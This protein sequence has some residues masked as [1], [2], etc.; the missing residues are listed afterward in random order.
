[1]RQFFGLAVL[2]ALALWLAACSQEWAGDDDASPSDDDTTPSDDDD[3]TPSDD[4]DTSP[5]FTCDPDS[6]TS[7]VLA[8]E[9]LFDPADP[10][11][12]DT[13]TVIIRST[14]GTEPAAAP[15]MALQVEGATGTSVEPTTMVAGGGDTLYYYA[16]ADVQLGDVCLTGLIDGAAQEISGK[17][18]VTPRPAGPDA[19][20]GV[21]KVTTNHQWTCAEQPTYGNEIHLYVLDEHGAGVPGSPIRVDYADSTDFDSIHN[22]GGDIPYSVTTDSNGYFLGYDYWPISDHGFVVFQLYL[23]NIASDIATEITTGWWETDDS[24]CNYCSTYAINTWGHWSHTVIWQLDPDASEICV[25]ETDHAG[26]SVCGAPGHLHHH[27]DHRAC[28][29]RV[30]AVSSVGDVPQAPDVAELASVGRPVREAH[31]VPA[32][33]GVEDHQ[34]VGVAVVVPRE[35]VRTRLREQIGDTDVVVPQVRAGP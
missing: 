34:H 11:P 35:A 30:V 29:G 19:S 13:L 15:S 18:T 24:D 12:G 20:N 1:M 28:W 26:Q 32:D 9:M 33:R 25:V 31:H 7:P 27:P 2:L 10:H 22:G 16:V 3:T 5:P 21:Y 8:G 17:V 23:D 4:D 6:L 14:N